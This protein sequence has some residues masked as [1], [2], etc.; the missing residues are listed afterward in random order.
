M[1]WLGEGVWLS[2][3]LSST[4]QLY[5]TS[6]YQHLQDLNLQPFIERMISEWRRHLEEEDGGIR[7][8]EGKRAPS[9]CAYQCINYC[10]STA[11][12]WH[13]QWYCP[14]NSPERE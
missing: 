1:A 6:T 12:D 9:L 7:F 5:H 4:L 11:L 13:W 10:S 8:S 2:V 3:R 14:F